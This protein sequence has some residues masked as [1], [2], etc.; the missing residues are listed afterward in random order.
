MYKGGRGNPITKTQ[1]KKG[2]FY[3]SGTFT[4]VGATSHSKG[5]IKKRKAAERKAANILAAGTPKFLGV[6]TAAKFGAQGIYNVQL[7]RS[8]YQLN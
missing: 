4:L 1:A 5:A 3:P 2:F 6:N 7:G 8:P